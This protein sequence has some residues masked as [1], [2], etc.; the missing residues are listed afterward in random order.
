MQASTQIRDDL[1]GTFR[2]RLRFDTPTRG[3]YATDASPF[4]IVPHGVA[5]PIDE[6]D[7]RTLVKY[8]QEAQLP[9]V[10]GSE[11]RLQHGPALILL[12]T[13]RAGYGALSRLITLGRR[14][15]DKGSYR[16]APQDFDGGLPGCLAL[17]APDGPALAATMV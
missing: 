1:R 11:M 8:A 6:E 5:V 17:L 15:A 9:L 16:I 7:L 3:L 12:A 2:G 10:I 14:R 13:D 4:E